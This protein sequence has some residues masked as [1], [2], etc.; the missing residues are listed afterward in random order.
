MS[1]FSDAR[2]IPSGTVLD[3]DLAIIGG[4][5]AGITLALSL[6]GKPIR[7]L[8]LESGGTSFDD[9]TQALYDGTQTG[10]PYTPLNATRQ[11]Y[12]GGGTN[13][14]GGWCRPL[15]ASDFEQRSWV[16]YSGWP[17]KKTALDPYYP[18]AQALVEAGPFDYEAK[19]QQWVDQYGAPLTLGAGGVYNS[20]FQ[21]SKMRG[22]ELPTNFGERYAADLKQIS[23]LTALLHANVTNI[24][25]TPDAKSVDHL[26]VA[27]L[28]GGKFTVKAK[29]IVLATGGMEN[30]RLLLAS[31][32]VM[33]QGVGNGNDLVGRFFMD[34]PV[35][36]NTAKLVVFAG[37]IAPYYPSNQ[38]GDGAIFRAALAVTDD[39]K[40]AAHVM[41][42]LTTV[43]NRIELDDFGKAVVA[44]TASALGIDGG[45]AAAYELGCGMELKPDPDRRL[46]LISARDA[47]GMPRLN[48]HMTIGDEDFALYR[49][50]IKE[51]GRQ[52][53]AAQTGL[54]H[55]DR[56]SRES[57]LETMDWGN[58]H[59]GTTRMHN[60]PKQGVVD[61]DLKV[62]GIGNLFV[63][64]SST[65]PT[66]GASNPTMNLVALALRL[67]DHIKGL[68]P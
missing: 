62:H 56:C 39:Y 44:T 42:S 8:M 60:D 22:S 12:L 65:F 31:N 57:W 24:A 13:H 10:V 61:A 29:H 1:A 49:Q 58:H 47:L 18:R 38:R 66:C 59:V 6:A 3:T 21:F 2:T 4:G 53:L 34:N 41:D 17:F 16:P 32:G 28:T 7:V 64:G 48:L 51:L 46:T 36:R 50:T 37:P 5:P 9:K 45:D 20:W 19:S 14:W 27:T 11:R 40:R 35:P 52:L 63:A 43:E 54:I 67:A 33:K 68:F 26:D 23:N 30:V 15:D 25:L 55:L